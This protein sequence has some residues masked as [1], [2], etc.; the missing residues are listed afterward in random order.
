MKDIESMT[1]KE[2]GDFLATAEKLRGFLRD[3]AAPTQ[4]IANGR[5][6]LVVDRGWIFAGDQSITEDGYVR[7][8]N[9]IHVF[10]WESIGFAKMRVEWKS[11]KVDLRPVTP[12]EVPTSAV[13]FRIP[14]DAGWG[15]K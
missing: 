4:Q 10:R 15:V 13:I 6:V 9:A 5:F 14:V 3:D 2:A 11:E 1:I 8:D 7:L 12:V